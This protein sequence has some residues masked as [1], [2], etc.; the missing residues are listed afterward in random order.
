MRRLIIKSLK[1]KPKLIENKYDV[2]KLTII[3]HVIFAQSLLMF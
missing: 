3:D 1:N 2:S